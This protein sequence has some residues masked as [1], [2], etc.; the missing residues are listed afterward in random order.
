MHFTFG[1]IFHSSA[2]KVL[3][4]FYFY[5]F[6]LFAIFI[7]WLCH[8]VCGIFFPDQGS[9]PHLLDWKNGGLTTGR[10]R[11]IPKVLINF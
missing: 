8:A 4:N 1:L 6:L 5:L 2:F 9:N 11:Q 10:S 3:I 7:L